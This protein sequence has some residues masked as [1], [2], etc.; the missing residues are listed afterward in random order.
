VTYDVTTTTVE[1][2]SA[3]GEQSGASYVSRTFTPTGSNRSLRGVLPFCGACVESI[4]SF[5]TGELGWENGSGRGPT[6]Y[7]GGGITATANQNFMLSNG[8]RLG[9]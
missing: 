8:L 6:T 7:F 1:A 5:E 2:A 3:N 4:S 9:P